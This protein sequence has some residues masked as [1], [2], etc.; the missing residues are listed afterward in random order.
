M[1]Y[2][3]QI[4]EWI[5]QDSDRM[6]ALECASRLDLKDW[7]LAAGFVRNLVWDK[8]HG[9]E[10]STP[11]NDIDLIYFDPDDLSEEKERGFESLLHSESEHPWSVKNQARM[12][13]RNKDAPYIST[14][15]AMSFWVELETAIGVRLSKRQGL[16]LVAPFGLEPLFQSSITINGKRKKP[17]AFMERIKNK[18][19]LEIWPKLSINC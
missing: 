19:W 14:A 8:L 6:A 10:V 12:H 13:T 2:E 9:Y 4:K 18:R 7:C 5:L 3:A 11:L 16:E 17:K 15:D 1:N